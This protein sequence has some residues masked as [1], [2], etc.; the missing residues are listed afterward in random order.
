MPNTLSNDLIN[1]IIGGYNSDPFAVLGPHQVTDD[2]GKPAIAIRAFLP[3]A[4][5]VKGFRDN[6]TMFEMW[7]IH[8]DGF[9][10]V[11][12]PGDRPFGYILRAD[13]SQ[14]GTIDIRDPYSYGPL[15][16]DFDLHLIHEGSHYR[17]YEKLGAHVT[18]VEGILGVHFA[19][20]APNAEHVGIM[21]SFNGWNG[22]IHPMRKHP[23]E[24]IWE[25][26]IP[27]LREG[28]SYKYQIKLPGTDI[29]TEKAD[30]Y[31]FFAE[32][33]PNT[34]SVVA[35]IDKHQWGDGEWLANRAHRQAMNAPISIYEVHLGSWKRTLPNS[36]GKTYQFGYRQL[37]HELVDYV[38]YMGF[39]HIEL[40]PITE[41]PYDGSWGYQTIGYYAVTS[42]FGTPEDFQYFVD[43]C[44]KNGIGVFL[45]WVPAH[46]PKDPHGLGMFDGT[47]LYEHADPR[48]GTHP[49]WGTLIFNYGRNEVRNFLL[50]NALFWL[51]KY[52]LDGLRVDAVASML[53]LNFS[54]PEG[55]WIPNKY[56][57]T[58]NLDAIDF[59][60]RFNELA[61][62]EHPGILT[63]AE[64]STDWPG[65]TR[66][67]FLGGLG[68]DLKWNMGW[69]NDILKYI[70]DDPIY[71]RFHHNLITFSLMY[72]FSEN[73][74]LPLSHDEVVHLK[75]SLINKMPGDS[76]Q[77]FAGLRLLLGYQFTHPGKKLLFMGDELAQREE[78]NDFTSIA[79]HDLINESHQGVQN[80]VRDLAN[81]YKNEPALHQIENSW[82]GFQWLNASDNE[83][84]IVSFLRRSR[85]EGQ[86]VREV[87][88]ICNWTPVAR[89]NYK[90][91]APRAGFYREV[92]NSDA[93]AYWGS[94]AGNA[95]GVWAVPDQWNETGWAI[96]LTVPPLSLLILKVEP[97]PVEQP[98][99]EPTQE[100]L[101]DPEPAATEEAQAEAAAEEP[102][103]LND[104]QDAG[105]LLEADD[106]EQ[107]AEE[108]LLEADEPEVESAVEEKP[109]RKTKKAD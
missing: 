90:I 109:K 59:L 41:H 68:F 48:L 93:G 95:G 16:S 44:H 27:G 39:T 45:D 56:G 105:L 77:Q 47:H 26:F 24:G 1:S 80:F 31:G 67:T 49:D 103:G 94:N 81:L 71:R 8:P 58:E 62:L 50:S 98:V 6:G 40:M 18:E 29:V 75:K 61:H 87:V 76:W 10:E 73:F 60:K 35:D 102:L 65:V 14:G 28:D 83:N 96:W 20:W 100:A 63:M 86:G 25:I 22:R 107:E 51:D 34:A 101:P 11:V 53:Y 104:I 38:K 69:M 91:P 5:G 74:L 7:R 78:W 57:G 33:R 99:P 88:V 21:G 43:H 13:N 4:A 37:A 46:F 2:D 36:E 106:S 70:K 92:L 9:F 97:T 85:D 30:P 55:S 66:P 89:E 54:R 32:Y 12:L 72:A 42:R 15:L 79:W 84:S 64:D 108:S 23:N 17:T 19:V 52:H 3:W 82:D